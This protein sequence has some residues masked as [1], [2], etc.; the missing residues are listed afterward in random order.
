MKKR[1][2]FTQAQ[3]DF[4][5]TNYKHMQLADLVKA[6]NEKFSTTLT[7]IQIKNKI[8]QIGIT[9]RNV[10]NN[11]GKY[12]D[13]M[14]EWLAKHH[15]TVK[16][17]DLVKMF[18][19]TF[20]TD[21]TKSAIWHKIDR[22][23]N[24]KYNRTRE[25]VPRLNWTKEL[26]TYLKE[27]YDH[28]SYN[29]LSNIMNKKFNIKTTTSSIEHKVYRL[30]LKKS[31]KGIAKSRDNK[32]ISKFWFKKGHI[33]WHKKQ[34]GYERVQP[35]GWTWVKVAEP[36]V[37]EA[38]HRVVWEKANGPIPKDKCIIFLDGN[39]GNFNLDNLK[40]INRSELVILNKMGL[41]RHDAEIT[42]TSLHIVRLTLKINERSKKL[43][44]SK[45]HVNR[46]K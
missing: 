8:R 18:N 9:K 4:I 24:I 19:E 41:E 11:Y 10:K 36:D 14:I 26:V 25:Y 30:G 33:P 3:V 38:K 37:F 29:D 46:F 2:R 27:N 45:K 1:F 31:E 23:K 40:L 28:Y 35:G 17:E 44:G 42:K 22:A 32:T 20:N 34:L 39:R 5:I 7:S 21:Y 43:H 15:N 12:T 6:F 13:E 16:L